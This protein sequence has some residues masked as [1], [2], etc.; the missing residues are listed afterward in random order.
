MTKF[1]VRADG[2]YLRSTDDSR[3][4]FP[5]AVEGITVAPESGRQVWDFTARAW[6]P[7]PPRTVKPALRDIPASVDSVPALRAAVNAFLAHQR[8]E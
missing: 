5:G 6:G 7:V 2:R 1:W 4:S 3:T 8:G